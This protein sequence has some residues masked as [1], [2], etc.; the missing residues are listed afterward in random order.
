MSVNKVTL[1]GR[2]GGDPT[3]RTV[4]QN[5]VKVAQFSLCTGS[6]YTTKDGKE[7]DDTAWHNIVAW[8]HLADVAERFVCK[9]AQ[10]MVL[11]RL[12]YRKYTDSNNIERTMTDIIAEDIELCG[13][14]RTEAQNGPAQAQTYQGNNSFQ[15]GFAMEQPTDDMPF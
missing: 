9:G 12:S 6:K 11:G 14:T 7:V 5:N 2:V 4:G 10:V 15:S 8:R 13:G 3:I 1:L